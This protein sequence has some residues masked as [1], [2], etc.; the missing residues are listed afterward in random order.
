LHWL[1]IRVS[2]YAA[3]WWLLEIDGI[4]SVLEMHAFIVEMV[5]SFEF[6]PVSRKIQKAYCDLAVPIV[7]GERE[8]GSQ[9]PLKIRPVN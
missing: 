5:R 4:V 7:V 6:L 1:A 3:E 2:S 8:K 9:L